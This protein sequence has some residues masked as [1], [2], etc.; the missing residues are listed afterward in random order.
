MFVHRVCETLYAVGEIDVEVLR[1]L[2]LQSD[3]PHRA[4]GFRFCRIAA[5]GCV[6]IA[7]SGRCCLVAAAGCILCGRCRFGLVTLLEAFRIDVRQTDV[8]IALQIRDQ[9]ADLRF[10]EATPLQMIDGRL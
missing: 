3:V 7:R 5:F 2:E 1:F 10:D 9:V 4:E 6:R 8:L